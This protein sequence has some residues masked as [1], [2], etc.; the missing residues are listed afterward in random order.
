MTD[1]SF[2]SGNGRRPLEDR[3]RPVATTNGAQAPAHGQSRGAPAA[4]SAPRRA[5]PRVRQRAGQPRPHG[6]RPVGARHR[7]GVPAC[8]VAAARCAPREWAHRG[9]RRAPGAR[10]GARAGRRRRGTRARGQPRQAAGRLDHRPRGPHELV[11]RDARRLRRAR[12]RARHVHPAGHS[13]RH[14]ADQA[15]R[16]AGDRALYARRNGLA[17]L[18]TPYGSHPN[19]SHRNGSPCPPP[20]APAPS[21]TAGSRPWR[22][23]T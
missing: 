5:G 20:T 13:R 3:S 4:R 10:R 1:P 7:A 16:M 18:G 6:S 15:Q 23:T 17:A 21:C 12:P 8:R 22:T 11:P 2:T 9:T 19:G 14:G